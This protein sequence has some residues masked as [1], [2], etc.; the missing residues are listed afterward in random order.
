MR[1]HE[2]EA[3]VQRVIEALK[4]KGRVEDCRVELK[5]DWINER[6]A[7]EWIAGHANSICGEPCLWIFGLDENQGLVGVK[8]DDLAVWWPQVKSFFDRAVRA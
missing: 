4:D 2:I 5:R 1:A 8:T 6:K 7:A 3:W